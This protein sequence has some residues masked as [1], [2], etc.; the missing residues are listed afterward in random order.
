MKTHL[1]GVVTLLLLHSTLVKGEEAKTTLVPPPDFGF[2]EKLARTGSVPL[3]T[4]LTDLI[5]KGTSSAIQTGL[6][7]RRE[8]FTTWS[9]TA[10]F[11]P[12]TA[13]S[14][15]Q[16]RLDTQIGD[17]K[18][19]VSRIPT[20][21]SSRRE[22]L[23]IGVPIDSPAIEHAVQKGY[24]PRL[25]E[26]DPRFETNVTKLASYSE[27]KSEAAGNKRIWNG[28]SVPEQDP[29]RDAVA[30]VGNNGICTGTL[31]APDTV[32]T[33]GHCYCGG[34]LSEALIGRNILSPVARI[35]IDKGRSEVFVSCE[36]LNRNLSLGDIAIIKLS[37]SAKQPPRKIGALD[38][39][40]E[41]ASVR[42]VGFGRTINTIGEKYQVNIVI[43]SFQ[44]DGRALTGIPD[45]QIYRCSPLHELVAASLNRDTCAGDSGGPIYAVGRD[46]QMYLVGLTSRAVDPDGRCGPGGIY[47]LLAVPPVRE[48]LEA[49]GIHLA[50]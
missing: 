47:V 14:L 40:R 15:G 36:K 37:R 28:I 22:F 10:T 19:D 43:A 49:R 16:Q 33:A 38:I 12:S 46:A 4:V 31:V 29:F 32:V 21:T 26:F 13:T 44:C 35:P 27:P 7:K 25:I 34:V 42:A 1:I 2:A 23:N 3:S 50:K 39:V 11:A 8:K 45:Y 9:D 41:A 48:W 18:Q 24:T 5:T 30:L 17:G 6:S 20:S